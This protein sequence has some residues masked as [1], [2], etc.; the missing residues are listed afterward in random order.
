MT[1]TNLRD[2]LTVKSFTSSSTKISYT[3]HSIT[4]LSTMRWFIQIAVTN[5][6]RIAKDWH[7]VPNSIY[8]N[9]IQNDV[10]PLYSKY[11]YGLNES[12]FVGNEQEMLPGS[13]HIKG[14]K[15]KCSS[16]LGSRPNCRKSGMQSGSSNP[17]LE[18]HLCH[19]FKTNNTGGEI[20]VS[21]MIEQ[22]PLTFSEWYYE[23]ID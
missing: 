21:G 14:I 16:D 6:T 22:S 20:Y 12:D 17:G 8:K 5:S 3:T 7:Y 13:S 4:T 19:Q 1:T 23:G 2:S 10:I 18:L 11:L 9:S 15:K